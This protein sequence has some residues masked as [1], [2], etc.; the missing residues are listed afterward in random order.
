DSSTVTAKRRSLPVASLRAAFREPAIRFSISSFAEV[1]G[2]ASRAV[3]ATTAIRRERVSRAITRWETVSSRRRM[4]SVLSQIASAFASGIRCPPQVSGAGRHS[5]PHYPHRCGLLMWTTG[6]GSAPRRD[7]DDRD[8]M[9]GAAPSGVAGSEGQ[10][11]KG[12]TGPRGRHDTPP[13]VR[14]G[15]QPAL[16]G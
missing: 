3:S 7:R 10:D 1:E 13:E 11:P 2:T 6:R 9:S 4:L 15:P 5:F 8:D 16:N 12:T 14:I